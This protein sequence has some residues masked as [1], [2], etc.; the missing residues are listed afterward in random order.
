[1]NG[2]KP[3]NLGEKWI[4]YII[5]Q[6]LR[7][8]S[9]SKYAPVLFIAFAILFGYLSIENEH[10][11]ITIALAVAYFCLTLIS[12]ERWHFSRIIVRQQAKIDNLKIELNAISPKIK[13]DH[14]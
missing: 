8:K 12:F 13:T 1:M 6:V 5:A 11:N 2:F 10:A 7:S 4:L 3:E 9:W 14:D